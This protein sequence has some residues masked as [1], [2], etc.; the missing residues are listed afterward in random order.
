MK[1]YARL[2][3][4]GL[5]AAALG[6]CGDDMPQVQVLRTERE[7]NTLGT[8]QVLGSPIEHAPSVAVITPSLD[9]L[10]DSAD[11]LALVLPTPTYLAMD[12]DSGAQELLLQGSVG[13][14]FSTAKALALAKAKQPARVQFEVLFDGEL[15]WSQEVLVHP[16]MP[17]DAGG[18]VRSK[19]LWARLPAAGL[20]LDGATRLE[21]RTSLLAGA[22]H[23]AGKPARAAFA[24]LRLMRSTPRTRS[25]A[26]AQK[27]NLVM[28]VMDTQRADR[29]V[30]YGYGRPTTPNL[31]RLAQRGLLYEDATS[32]SSWTWPAAAS[33]MTG[34][35]PAAH[36][37]LD[38]RTGFLPGELETLAEALQDRGFATG[39]F[40]GNPIVSAQRNFDQGFE[41]FESS[42]ESVKGDQVVPR[43]LEWLNQA[44]QHR[45]FLYVHLQDPHLPHAPRP[46]DLRQFTGSE[47][48]QQDP[49]LLQ[50]RSLDLLKGARP[51]P[52]GLPDGRPFLSAQELKLSS[53]LY[54][55][56]VHQ[57]DHWLGV[58]LDQLDAWRLTEN[59]IVA[60]TADHGEEFLEHQNLLHG[61]EL[62][63]ELV[64]VPLILAGPGLPTGERM[65][66]PVSTST[67]PAGLAQLLDVP[68][69][70]GKL[71]SLLEAK[72]EPVL[73]ETSKG[74]WKGSNETLILGLREG[75]WVLHWA[76][77]GRPWG[78]PPAA[79]PKGG[80]MRLYNLATDPGETKDLAAAQ[81]ERA[82]AMRQRLLSAR[83]EAEAA[84][85]TRKDRAGAGTHALLQAIGYAGEDDE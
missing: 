74:Y 80:E 1:C 57:G 72:S 65:P 28:V 2:L 16:E 23:L 21:L 4:A 24:D 60:Y 51:G 37:V 69:G 55:A 6:S 78:T 34:L 32:P 17:R 42:L 47:Q 73:F 26:S 67:L 81:P 45:F 15:R 30:P 7:L 52:G 71:P 56:C 59:T 49:N 61:H 27:P 14:H 58:L 62:W 9:H 83:A 70:G 44:R 19:N 82:E 20:E 31:E 33:L 41:H 46:R 3:L 75:E 18:A 13:V 25:L 76:P 5:L 39:G 66:M 85:P 11:Q 10:G 84:A 36:G 50:Q 64:H 22:E 68:F 40:S 79:A 35:A 54:D 53:A 38:H 77:A 48:L 63:R 8:W 12:L 43:A 29:T